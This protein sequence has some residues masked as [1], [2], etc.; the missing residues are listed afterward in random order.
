MYKQSMLILLAVLSLSLNAQPQPQPIDTISNSPFFTGDLTRAQ[1]VASNEGK[2]YILYFSAGW[3]MPCQWMEENTFSNIS[4]NAYLAPRYLVLKVDIDDR[5]GKRL[6]RQF[7]VKVLPTL[8]IFNSQGQLLQRFEQAL[9]AEKL[10]ASL[11]VYDRP[12]NRLAVAVPLPPPPV[13]EALTTVAPPPS[14]LSSEKNGELYPSLVPEAPPVI[15]KPIVTH[16]AEYGALPESEAPAPPTVEQE[17]YLP[18]S[19]LFG[20]QIG[21]FSRLDNAKKLID[22]IEMEITVPLEIRPA[23]QNG[24]KLYKVIAGSFPAQAQAEQLLRQLQSRSLKGFVQLLE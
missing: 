16:H 7:E 20:V 2:L 14:T 3:C 19:P 23:E 1:A 21:A 22:R 13:E 5:E 17:A 6:Q 11:E 15:A 9:P 18:T 12:D 4:L 8:L 10:L 24:R